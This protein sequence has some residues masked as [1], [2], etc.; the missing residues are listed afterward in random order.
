MAG[1]ADRRDAGQHLCLVGD[2]GQPVAVGQQVVP[3]G[4]DEGGLRP[5]P[6][7]LRLVGP[8]VEVGLRHV[9][10][11]IGEV[12]RPVSRDKARAVV[13]MGMGQDDVVHLAGLDPRGRKVAQQP[14]GLVAEH[15][16]PAHAAVE[17]HH[18]LADVQ[19]Q[20]VLFQ[21][22]RADGQELVLQDACDG[23]GRGGG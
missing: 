14:P 5:F 13:D 19:D 18:P 16:V 12:Q 4:L 10:L 20:A 15:G 2:K 1:R 21:H 6:R 23:V 8:E 11:R 3:R 9:K 7:Q 22:H 17:Q